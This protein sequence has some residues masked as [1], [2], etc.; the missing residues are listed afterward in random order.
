MPRLA[1]ADKKEIQKKTRKKLL[2]TAAIEFATCG[3]TGANINRISIAAGFAKGTI[4]NYFPSK[5]ALMLALIDEIGAM[6]TAHIVN[7]IETETN[8]NAKVKRFFEAGF[9]FVEQYPHKAQVAISA[10]YGFDPEFKARIYQAYQELFDLIIEGIIGE[11]IASNDFRSNDPNFTAALLMS[12]YL[13][14]SSLFG[15]D[16]RVWFDPEK[17]ASFVLDGIRQC[18]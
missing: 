5:R 16:G 10:V 3:F 1:V 13:G 9:E 7:Q 18:K 6:H 11:G 17:V 8:P 15:P 4:Y 14:G 12:L 2:N